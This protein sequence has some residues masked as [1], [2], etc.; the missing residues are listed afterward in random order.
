MPRTQKVLNPYAQFLNG[1]DPMTVIQAT[2]GRLRT[3]AKAIGIEKINLAPAPGKWSAREILCH[4]ADCEMAFGFRL[5]QT[6]A[7]NNHKIQPFDQEKWA[8]PY[9]LISADDA[10]ATFAALRRWNVLLIDASL[11]ANAGKAVV[12]PE[13]GKMTFGTIVETMAGHDLNHIAQLERLA[14]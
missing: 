4:L 8:T 7:E 11:P 1:Q 3:L 10:L 13:R 14:I 12:H 6:L 5:R 2:S 9:K